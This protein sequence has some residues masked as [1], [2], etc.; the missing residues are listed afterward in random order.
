MHICGVHFLDVNFLFPFMYEKY[1]ASKL[2]FS[3]FQAAGV[4]HP[5]A[6]SKRSGS[7]AEATQTL[8]DQ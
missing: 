8:F 7:A 5:T 3:L 4:E 1:H 2:C 6:V